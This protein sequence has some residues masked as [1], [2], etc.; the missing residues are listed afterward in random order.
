[1]RLAAE[2]IGDSWPTILGIV[3][4]ATQE[5]CGGLGGENQ[6]AFPKATILGIVRFATQEDCGGLRRR[7]SRSV[8]EGEA[9]FPAAV[10][11]AGKCPNLGR[12]SILCAAGKLVSNFPA[13]SKCAG[14]LFQQRIL[15]SHSL[16]E[17]SEC[18]PKDSSAI[19]F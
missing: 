3:Q 18:R 14:K 19:V 4:F 5:D 8:P 9:E 6:G 12:D 1:M 15:D 17:F 2:K 7:K 13:A 16:L 11:L 10:F